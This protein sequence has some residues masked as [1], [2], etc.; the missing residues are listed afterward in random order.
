MA[1]NEI[2][3]IVIYMLLFGLIITTIISFA[4][5]IAVVMLINKD[6]NANKKTHL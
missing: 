6:I 2:L 5:S 4:L 3:I 1:E